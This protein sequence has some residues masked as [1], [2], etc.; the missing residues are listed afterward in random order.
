MGGAR[1][2]INTGDLLFLLA[3]LLL[4]VSAIILNARIHHIFSITN[5]A[6]VSTY[7]HSYDIIASLDNNFMPSKPC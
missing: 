2:L 4:G 5:Q 1:R 7:R 6:T 3:D